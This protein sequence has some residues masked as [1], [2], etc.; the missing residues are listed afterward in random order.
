MKKN[1][2]IYIYINLETVDGFHVGHCLWRLSHHKLFHGN[3]LPR[4]R[5]DITEKGLIHMYMYIIIWFLNLKLQ[6][7]QFEQL[8]NNT[9][10][11][12]KPSSAPNISI[13]YSVS[14][15]SAMM[16]NTAWLRLLISFNLVE[17]VARTTAPRSIKPFFKF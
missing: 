1:K 10:T 9:R 3:F 13:S 17:P 2:N 16:M 15:C 8:L 7:N 5:V 14:D 12:T 4:R 6:S 11:H